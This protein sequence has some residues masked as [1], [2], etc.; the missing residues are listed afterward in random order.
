MDEQN[1]L[2][3]N[4]TH[5]DALDVIEEENTN[6]M[7]R[8]LAIMGKHD[9]TTYLKTSIWTHLSKR[10]GWLVILAFLGLISGSIL[11]TYV[12]T[13]TSL[14][15]LA[16]NMLMLI[17]TGGTTGSQAATVMVLALALDS[18]TFLRV[19]FISNPNSIPAAFTLTDIG[20][21]IEIRPSSDSQPCLDY[22]CRHHR[23][24]HLFW[25]GFTCAGNMTTTT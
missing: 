18:L 3:G 23:A 20:C 25:D 17:D 22:H 8:F 19:V 7:E 6:D 24:V 10:V 14:M 15:I 4:I 9:N 1:T 13:L 21:C 16:F 2:L 11:E 5:D 12:G